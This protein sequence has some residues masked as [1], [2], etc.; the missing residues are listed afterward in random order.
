MPLIFP[1]SDGSTDE[2]DPNELTFRDGKHRVAPYLATLMAGLD[3]ERLTLDEAIRAVNDGLLTDH[4]NR[5][6]DDTVASH[7]RNWGRS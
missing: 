7:L 3:T 1:G 4:L 5:V 6:F 2:Q